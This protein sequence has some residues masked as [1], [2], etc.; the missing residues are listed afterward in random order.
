MVENLVNQTQ[1]QVLVIEDEEEIRELIAL[2][3]VRQG[4][5]V[6]KASTAVEALEIIKKNKFHLTI[7]DWMMPE[8][9][10]LE[11]LHKINKENPILM[12]TAKA[13]PQ[14]IVQGLEAGADDYITKP[15]EPSVFT[16]RVRALLR[17]KATV[18]INVNSIL[19]MGALKINLST[20]EVHCG[21]DSLH[22]TPSEFKILLELCNHQGR[23][24]TRDFLVK[25][26]QGEG[27]TV[28]GRTIDTH[29]FGLRKKMGACVDTIETIR[30]V[31]Y[32]VR[33]E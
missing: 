31:G 6:T 15:F 26:V 2:L 29:V 18:E 22:L 1:I 32:R 25:I 19:Q 14:N 7:L 11:F 21:T 30:G 20:Y 10:G 17:R 24:L 13:E 27:V 16:A 5:S 4:Y 28:T 9:S 8:M 12:V 23:V 33:T 3:L